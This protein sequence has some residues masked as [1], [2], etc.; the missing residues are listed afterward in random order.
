[1][2]LPYFY[3]LIAIVVLCSSNT[4]A[5][6]QSPLIEIVQSNI[7]LNLKRFP[8]ANGTYEL[9]HTD[10][11]ELNVRIS[12]RKITRKL[13]YPDGSIQKRKGRLYKLRYI[14]QQ[15]ATKAKATEAYIVWENGDVFYSQTEKTIILDT[16]VLASRRY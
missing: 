8:L 12:S 1:M 10:Q 4:V 7:P 6:Q 5:T 11:Q 3:V 13:K 2:K 14:W 15:Q 9:L 16:I